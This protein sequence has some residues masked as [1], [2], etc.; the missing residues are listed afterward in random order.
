MLLGILQGPMWLIYMDP[1]T[2]VVQKY[3]KAISETE[4]S[5]HYYQEL[6]ENLDSRVQK[7]WEDEMANAQAQCTS[8]ISAM[9]IFNLAI[10]NSIFGQFLHIFANDSVQLQPAQRNNLILF[11]RS[12]N[13]TTSGEAQHGLLK[14][15]Q[16]RNRSK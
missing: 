14:A 15:Y 11:T 1:A 3:Q 12:R 16:S 5:E 8:D 2:S 4:K 6:C 9:D 7:Q 10:E 13:L